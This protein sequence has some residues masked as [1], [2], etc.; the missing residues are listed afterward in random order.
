MKRHVILDKLGNA[1]YINKDDLYYFKTDKT[2]N[3]YSVHKNEHVWSTAIDTQYLMIVDDD[4]I[5]PYRNFNTIYKIDQ[6]TGDVIGKVDSDFS[7]LNIC[8][9]FIFGELGADN[10]YFLGKISCHDFFLEKLFSIGASRLI[11]VFPGRALFID[12]HRMFLRSLEGRFEIIWN[13]DLSLIEP[14]SDVRLLGFYNDLILIEINSEVIAGIEGLAG[15]VLWTIPITRFTTLPI[16]HSDGFIY[17][18]IGKSIGGE[19][20][21]INCTTGE[22]VFHKRLPQGWNQAFGTTFTNPA[23]NDYYF[24]ITTAKITLTVPDHHILLF[25]K[26]TAEVE[27]QITLEKREGV[28]PYGPQFCNSRLFQVDGGNMLQMFELRM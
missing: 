26:D 8:E 14:V 2:V 4:Y 17:H 13:L 22:I 9:G 6:T 23:V 10:D 20:Y 19:Y 24:A 7:P 18:L 16:L 11:K 12:Q 27:K 1:P 28:I 15:I 5:Y 25:N 3:K 21:K